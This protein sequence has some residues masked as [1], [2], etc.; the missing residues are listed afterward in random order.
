MRLP[1]LRRLDLR[2][3]PRER[4]GG[5]RARAR[6]SVAV[7]HHRRAHA[8]PHVDPDPEERLRPAHDDGGGRGGTHAESERPEQGVPAVRHGGLRGLHQLHREG[9]GVEQPG[10]RQRL[11]P[12]AAQVAAENDSQWGNS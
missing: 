1:R 5:G 3:A 10:Q 12:V 6:R 9:R 11:R 8:H 7:R 2:Q 4:R